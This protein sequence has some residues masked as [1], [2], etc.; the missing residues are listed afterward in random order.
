[1]LNCS[2]HKFLLVTI[3][4]LNVCAVLPASADYI[5]PELVSL[6]TET[7]PLEAADIESG[8]FDYDVSWQGIPVASSVVTISSEQMSGGKHYFVETSTKTAK[9]IDLLYEMRHQSESIFNASNFAPVSFSSYQNENSKRK[10]VQVLFNKDGSIFSKR[11]KDG[12]EIQKLSFNPANFTLD[13][14]TAAFFAKS[15]PIKIGN[16]ASFDV[17]NGKNR[18]LIT[19]KVMARETLEIGDKEY[20]TFRVVPHVEK[21]TDTEKQDKRLKY[22]ELWITADAKRQV[23]QLKSEVAVGSVTAKLVKYSPAPSSS[24]PS[25]NSLLRA[26][27]A[28][29]LESNN[30]KE[31]ETSSKQ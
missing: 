7:Y 28:S 13:P 5:S 4:L 6:K 20:D 23:V 19:F 3:A 29:E 27:L 1:M 22:A 14:I 8:K 10:I 31:R 15:I 30:K 21:L 17:F 9:V 11:W 18:F 24:Q 25:S 16:E 26:R 2:L 12:K